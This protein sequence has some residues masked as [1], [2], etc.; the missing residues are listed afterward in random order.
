MFLQ[1]SMAQFDHLPYVFELAR[2]LNNRCGDTDK[3]SLKYDEY[4]EYVKKF[5]ELSDDE[6]AKI[7]E[8]VDSKKNKKK[9]NVDSTSGFARA[10]I[11]I[12]DGL[13]MVKKVCK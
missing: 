11:R 10:S 4:S 7:M 6:R 13:S 8:K 9:T 2:V 3:F 5:N 1:K 12:R